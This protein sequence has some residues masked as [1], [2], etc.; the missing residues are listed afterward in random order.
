[1]IN[2]LEYFAY[3]AFVNDIGLNEHGVNMEFALRIV[4]I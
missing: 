4:N 1:M 3:K 2:I